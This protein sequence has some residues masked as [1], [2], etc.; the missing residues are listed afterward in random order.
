VYKALPKTYIHLRFLY[1]VLLTLPVT[2]ASVER[3]F[4]ELALVKSKPTSTMSQNRHEA[5]FSSAVEKDLLLGLKDANLAAT[6]DTKADRRMLL[7]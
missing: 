3:S 5:L 7:C 1:K 6:F 4:S 2:T